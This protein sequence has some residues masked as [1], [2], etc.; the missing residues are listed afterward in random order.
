MSSKRQNVGLIE[1]ARE[2]VPEMLRAG[3]AMRL[4]QHEQAIE[5]AAARGFERGANF[6][7]MMAV[8]VHDRDV[9]HRAFNVEAAADAGKFRQA[10]ANQVGGDVQIEADSSRGGSVPH[11][12]DAGRMRQLK[13]AEVVAFVGEAKSAAQALAS[14]CR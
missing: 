11:I 5:F 13:H 6:R 12:V 10:F 7:G 3:V 2:I 9:V 14:G 1:G 4:E 8:I